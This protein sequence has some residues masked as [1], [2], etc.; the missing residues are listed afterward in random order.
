MSLYRFAHTTSLRRVLSLL[1]V[2]LAA[3]VSVAEDTEAIHL[4]PKWKAGDSV[5]YELKRS[6]KRHRGESVIINR[7]MRFELDLNVKKVTETGFEIAWKLGKARFDEPGL[8]GD[9]TID[10]ITQA[11]ANVEVI[12]ET[13]ADATPV[14]IQNWEE[15]RKKDTR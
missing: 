2:I 15:A 8:V 4:A 10:T 13:D 3:S 6:F 12:V 1:Y 11:M 5:R 7:T 9:H 14:S